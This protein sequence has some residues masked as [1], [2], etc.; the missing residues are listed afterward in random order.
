MG[1]TSRK[2][3]PSLATKGLKPTVAMV[4]KIMFESKSCYFKYCNQFRAF[5]EQHLQK[6]NQVF[7]SSMEPIIMTSST[8]FKWQEL[9]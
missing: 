6:Y 8:N 5:S 7:I 2:K 3:K 9:I 1:L 4:T